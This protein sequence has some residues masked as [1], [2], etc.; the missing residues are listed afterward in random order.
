MTLDQLKD[1]A[2]FAAKEAGIFLKNKK[3]ENKE[4]FNPT[5]AK[6][7]SLMGCIYNS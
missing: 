2:V 4:V 3:F 7:T 6:S 5:G 1:S